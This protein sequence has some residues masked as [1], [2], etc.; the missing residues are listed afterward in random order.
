MGHGD[1]ETQR[2]VKGFLRYPGRYRVCVIFSSIATRE[3]GGNA[4][5]LTVKIPRDSW[6]QA[7]DQFSAA[8]EGWLVSV[9]LLAPTIGAQP[10]VRDLPLVGVVAEPPDG[11]GIISISAARSDFD[12]ITH[13]IHAPTSV[14]IERTDKG[15][16]AALQI[17][18]AE[19][20][21]TIVRLKTPALPET[22][23]GVVRTWSE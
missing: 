4:P 23:D 1:I 14:W 20:T 2:I 10:E 12:Q 18:S 7:L 13:T 11:G 19:G 22:V 21:T 8:H 16:D 6:P 15:A 5:M 17:E 3:P 9:D